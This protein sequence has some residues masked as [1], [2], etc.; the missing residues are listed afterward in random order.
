MGPS[1]ESASHSLYLFGVCCKI[2]CFL[3]PP[4]S[5]LSAF[6]GQ[7]QYCEERALIEVSP[8]LVPLSPLQADWGPQKLHPPL[9]RPV[10]CVSCPRRC[11][12]TLDLNTLTFN[13]NRLFLPP[14]SDS[15]RP[16]I[17]VSRTVL[18][19]SC[20]TGNNTTK[21]SYMTWE[22]VTRMLAPITLLHDWDCRRRHLDKHIVN[23][24]TRNWHSSIFA[25]ELD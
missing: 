5:A 11:S 25:S 8:C 23:M 9:E 21:P 15:T 1:H 16:L 19:R 2:W 7:M 24:N 12:V 20:I 14:N 4:R 13:I 3:A 6:E 22:G 18:R 10:K 17:H